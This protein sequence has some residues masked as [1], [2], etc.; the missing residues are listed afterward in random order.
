MGNNCPLC[1]LELREEEIF[2]EDPMFIVLRTR[3]LK[4][5]RERI[6]IVAKEHIH[7]VDYVTYGVALQTAEEVGKIVFAYAPKFVIMD[8]TFATIKEHWHLVMTDLNPKSKDFD[9]ILLTRWVKVVDN[10]NGEMF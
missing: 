9:Q 10:I 6:M 5:H 1:N 8:S 2:Y 4:G 3:D 7:S